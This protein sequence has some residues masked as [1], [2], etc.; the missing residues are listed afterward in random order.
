[1]QHT[2]KVTLVTVVVDLIKSGLQEGCCGVARASI[3]P[4]LAEEQS[5][6]KSTVVEAYERLIAEGLIRAR[7]G[8]G[9][10]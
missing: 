5:V 1:M 2:A 3:H 4:A 9:F 10:L 8:T 7:Q 6:S